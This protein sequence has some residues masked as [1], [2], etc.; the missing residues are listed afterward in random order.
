MI[1][2]DIKEIRYLLFEMQRG[3]FFKLRLRTP[4]PHSRNSKQLHPVGMVG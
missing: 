3:R 4:T 1:R 2:T